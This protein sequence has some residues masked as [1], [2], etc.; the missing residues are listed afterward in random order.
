MTTLY[1]QEPSIEIKG[2]N[3]EVWNGYEQIGQELLQEMK[4]K[5]KLVLTIECYPTV[6]TEEIVEGLRRFNLVRVIYS[7]RAVK[8]KAQIEAMIERFLTDDRVFGYMAPF[9]IRDFYDENKLAQL[10]DEIESVAGG[11]VIVIGT[12]ATLVT[13]GDTLVYA[14]MA[15]WKIQLRYRTHEFGNWLADNHSEDI[16]RKYKRGYNVEWRAAD[17]LKR[18]Y[19]ASSGFLFGYQRQRRP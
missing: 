6:R 1:N 19:I 4:E 12:G 15:R 13:R 5:H 11:L 2:R 16:L 17:R 10:R 18:G 3:Q 7:E 14:D 8:N 9:E